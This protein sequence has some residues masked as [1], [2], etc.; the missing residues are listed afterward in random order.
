MFNAASEG[1]EVVYRARSERLEVHYPH[2]V[3]LFI[4]VAFLDCS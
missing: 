4:E 1:K 2:C 3:A